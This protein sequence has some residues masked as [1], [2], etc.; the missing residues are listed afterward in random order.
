M[1]VQFSSPCSLHKWIHSKS[2]EITWC[3]TT[4]FVVVREVDWP[5]D[6]IIGCKSPCDLLE[7][8]ERDMDLEKEFEEFERDEIVKV[9]KFNK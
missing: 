6:H 7:F 4:P 8:F 1:W 9:Y 5:N 2:S 3:T